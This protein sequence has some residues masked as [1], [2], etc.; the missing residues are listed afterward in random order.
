MEKFIKDYKG[1]EHLTLNTETN[2]L[3]FHKV[4]VCSL[5]E[6]EEEI[7]WATDYFGVTEM[8]V[9]I[10]TIN[11]RYHKATVHGYKYEV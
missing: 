8:E 4:A 1:I 9:I 5:T 3:S 11:A 2:V 6:L 7:E 10:R